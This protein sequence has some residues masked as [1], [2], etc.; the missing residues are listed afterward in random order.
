LALARAELIYRFG[1]WDLPA[2]CR[3]H[4]RLAGQFGIDHLGT[5]VINTFMNGTMET[6]QYQQC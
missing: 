4:G 6:M 1:E 3:D 5:Q 2:G